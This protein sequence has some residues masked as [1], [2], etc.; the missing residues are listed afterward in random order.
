[1][2]EQHLRI[3]K[4]GYFER[5]KEKISLTLTFSLPPPRRRSPLIG[6]L[7]SMTLSGALCRDVTAL[8]LQSGHGALFLMVRMF[9]LFPEVEFVHQHSNN[10]PVTSFPAFSSLG[11]LPSMEQ[12]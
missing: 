4:M 3:E 1:M 5:L 12:G 8:K 7:G 10:I 11:F 9:F 6:L 2:N